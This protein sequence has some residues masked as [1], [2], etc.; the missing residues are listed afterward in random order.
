M[1]NKVEVRLLSENLGTARN[2]GN[3]LV[4]LGN[5]YEYLCELDELVY[6]SSPSILQ[7]VKLASR[8]ADE[9]R[10]Q[11]SPNVG[12]FFHDQSTLVLTGCSFSSPGF[13]EAIAKLSPI[14][15]LRVYLQDRHERERDKTW[16]W[17]KEKQREQVEILSKKMKVARDLVKLARDVG[18]KE[19]EIR[20]LVIDVLVRPLERLDVFIENR[21]L[22]GIEINQVGED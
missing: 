2:V 15:T 4:W 20:Q 6:C 11:L 8:I 7:V 12:M 9:G 21:L 13:W 14:E 10:P 16:H 5:V 22:T 17:D 19:E 1:S 3:F 18:M